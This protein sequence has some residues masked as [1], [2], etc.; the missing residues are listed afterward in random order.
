[1]LPGTRTDLATRR[2]RASLSLLGP[3]SITLADDAM[4]LQ[5]LND[6]LQ[7]CQARE[8]SCGYLGL[9]GGVG[10]GFWNP[11]LERI[12]GDYLGECPNNSKAPTK[13]G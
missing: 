3:V 2:P 9:L 11:V 4:R 5:R 7:L 13:T 6:E 8:E 10:W 12:L 1:M